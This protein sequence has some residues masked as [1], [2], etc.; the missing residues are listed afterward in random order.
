MTRG[1]GVMS[2]GGR[3]IALCAGTMVLLQPGQDHELLH[4]SPDF[5]LFVLAL[6]PTLAERAKVSPSRYQNIVHNSTASLAPWRDAWLAAGEL[7]DSCGVETLLAEHFVRLLRQFEPAHSVCRRALGRL[8]E[9]L[10]ASEVDLARHLRVHPSDLSRRIRDE[11]GMRLVE[12]R[13]RL[14]LLRFVE[15][16]DAGD[17]L[18][19]AAYASGFGS[20]TQCFR[21]F[22]QHLDCS[23]SQYFAIRSDM[24]ERLQEAQ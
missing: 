7:N 15:R 11:L 10:D 20:Y 18:T 6:S 5:E 22:E 13:T 21:A 4:E 23:P 16:V 12:Y 14:R 3:T 9:N 19:R 8:A 2:V 24:A 17:S 1:S